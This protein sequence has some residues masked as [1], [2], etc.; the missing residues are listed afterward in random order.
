MKNIF[1][2][3]LL[4]TIFASFGGGFLVGKAYSFV[5]PV[6]GA[7]NL[8]EGQPDGTDFS[9]F[10]DAWR[11]VQ[12]DY[13]GTDPLDFQ[14]MVYGAIDGMIGSLGD[15]YTNFMTAQDTKIFLEDVE[16]AFS[17]V[18]MEIGIRDE[19]LKVI[20]P[21]EG[22]PAEQAGLRADDH[23]VRI[24]EDTFTSDLTI[25]EAVSYI[26]GPEGS[27]VILSIFREGWQEPRDFEIKRAVISIPSLRYEVK[28]GNIAYVK[29][30]QFSE[31][32]RVDF[33]DTARKIAASGADKIIIDVRNN[34]GGFLHVAVDIAGYFVDRGDIVVI[35]DFGEGQNRYEH[36]ATG[37]SELKNFKVVVLMNKGSASASEILAG[38]LRDNNNI[39]LIGEKSF[40]KGSVQEIKKLKDNSSIKVTIAKWLTPKGD[41]IAEKGLEPD[42]EVEITED[43]FDSGRD[44]QLDLAIEELSKL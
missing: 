13:V 19:K 6:E 34:P 24:D 41:L 38:A 27:I 42:I 28:E 16:G 32:L 25:D 26:R 20:A 21:L 22:T 5:P 23:I 37:R 39:L 1:I 3:I 44:P 4:F 8:N 15:P 12:E 31:A 17:G 35:E 14:K 11:V 40:G 2:G 43:D 29:L 10:W 30:F 36:K 7:I 18:G 9:L 33:R